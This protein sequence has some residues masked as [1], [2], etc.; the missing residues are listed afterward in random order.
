MKIITELDYLSYKAHLTFNDKGD[1]RYKTIFGGILSLISMIISF[2]FICYFLLKLFNKEDATVTFNEE[3]DSTINMTNSHL[4]P[5]MLRLSDAYSI[6]INHENIYNISLLVWYSYFDEKHNLLQN[7][8]EIIVEKCNINKHFG[9]YKKYFYHINDLDTYFCPKKRLYNQTLYG[10]YGEQSEYKYYMFY[11]SKCT[12]DSNNNLCL[13]NEIIDSLLS[14]SFLDIKYLSYSLDSYKSENQES[15]IVISDRFLVSS[16]VYKRIWLYFTKIKYLSDN[17]LFFP[18]KHYKYFHQ[19]DYL[20]ID[21]DLR[22][23]SLNVIPNTFLSLTMLNSG[24]IGFYKRISLKIQDYLATI[25]GII[26]AITFICQCLNY[27]NA[28]NSYYC[29]LIKDFLIE[30]QIQKKNIKINEITNSKNVSVFDKSDGNIFKSPTL[31][32]KTK[33]SK[34]KCQNLENLQKSKTCIFETLKEKELFDKKIRTNFLPL[35]FSIKTYQDKK[36]MNWYI[37]NINKRLNVIN[38]LN[39]LEQVEKIKKEFYNSLIVNNIENKNILNT[40]NDK[41]KNCVKNNFL[42]NR[43]QFSK[44]KKTNF[45]ISLKN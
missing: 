5:L 19:F 32:Y 16:T 34:F 2:S 40:I 8:D 25:G 14:I 33:P 42:S 28:R 30:N 22:N 38:V 7:Y 15:L 13:N 11:I 31:Q 12:N 35:L 44:F 17:G 21:A 37:K 9:E 6:P 29:I 18:S 43:E 4:L 26:K 23:I 27:F 24:T 10:T 20:R 3:R 1:K 45:E 39:T 41:Y 36:E